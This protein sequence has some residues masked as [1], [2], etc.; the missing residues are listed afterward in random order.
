MTGGDEGAGSRDAWIE[1]A[2]SAFAREF[3]RSPERV[4]L[5]P[6]RVN[7]IGEHTDYN[8]GWAVP[9]AIDR[10]AMVLAAPRSDR[11]VRVR[12]WDIA[13][14]GEFPS[15][16]PRRQ[17]TWLDYVGGIF[18]A[19]AEEGFD[20]RGF[21][22]GIT[23]RVPTR[24][25]LSSSAAL[26]VAL[27]AALDGGLDLGLSPLDWAR[28]A[29]RGENVFVGVRCGILDPFASALG[30]PG[31]ALKLD[32]RSEEFELVPFAGRELAI[33]LVHSGVERRVASG[34]YSQRVGEC[35]RAL[36][37][38]RE[39]GV[40]SR[41]ARSLR[42][43]E[44]ADLPGLEAALDPVSFRRVRHVLSENVRVEE[45]CRALEAG[46]LDALGV[47]LRAAQ[48]SLRDDYAV[49]TPEIDWLCELGDECEG[50]VGS[51]LTGAGLGGFTLHLVFPDQMAMATESICSGFQTRF[52][53]RPETLAVF[54]SR[55]AWI[56]EE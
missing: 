37:M 38:A 19:L 5:A 54:P 4:A 14:S 7:L 45:F 43:L 16:A 17:G 36:Q 39:A 8:E 49:S 20:C 28:I 50:V 2:R 12:A 26:G 41:S 24:A 21:D 10:Q 13:E 22:L 27:A 52:D 42:D 1:A 35:A 11:Q 44:L 32:C 47:S 29:H 15:D 51:R 18:F 55:G 40:A 3:G 9:C 53:R 25:G 56:D 33:L 30:Q 46:D 31:H 34:A 23:S 6:G 48:G